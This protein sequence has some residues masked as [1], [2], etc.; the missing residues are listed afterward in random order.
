MLGTGQRGQLTRARNV[1]VVQMRLDDVGDAQAPGTGFSEVDVD[2]SPRIDDGSDGLGVVNDEGADMAQ[3]LDHELTHVHAPRIA[4]A[5]SAPGG[6]N[7]ARLRR[8]DASVVYH[9]TR[10]PAIPWSLRD[11]TP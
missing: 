1:V 3:A 7:R 2:V 8:P 5:P 11:P 10:R 9:R 4:V 6:R